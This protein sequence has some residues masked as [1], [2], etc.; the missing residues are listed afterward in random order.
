VRPAPPFPVAR[1]PPLP[2]LDAQFGWGKDAQPLVAALAN[3]L[4]Q[5]MLE[6]V[7][8]AYAS[9][10]IPK[11]AVLLGCSEDEAAAGDARGS[12]ASLERNIVACAKDR[13]RGLSASI[14]VLAS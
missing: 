8:R 12:C 14:T 13:R 1:L 7:Q 9:I 11:L 4:R 5:R 3:Q 2:A 10:G 6:L